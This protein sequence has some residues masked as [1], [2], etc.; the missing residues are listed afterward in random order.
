MR[1]PLM[2]VWMT[3]PALLLAAGFALG[4]V[5][6]RAAPSISPLTW[7]GGAILFLLIGSAGWG[8]HHRR[9]VS[10]GPLIT[11]GAIAGSAITIGGA[12][13]AISQQV[14]ANHITRVMPLKAEGTSPILLGRV[15]DAPDRDER[16]IR[17]TLRIQQVLRANDTLR[18][19]GR[20]RAGLWHSP[21]DST[22]AYPVVHQGALLRIRASVDPLPPRLN[23]ADFDYGAYLRRR[24]VY[25]V[26]NVYDPESVAV[27]EQAA[28]SW[29]V[30]GIVSARRYVRS[31]IRRRVPSA[32]SRGVLQALLLGDRSGISDA[33]QERFARTGLMHLLA[34][35]G[36]HVLL[37]GMVLYGL[38]GPALMRLGWG[39]RS[40]EWSRAALTMALLVFYALLTGGRPSVVRAV[41]MASLFIGGV[42]LQRPTYSLNTLGVAALVLL[43][44]RPAALFDA[45][46]QLSFAAVSAIV[47]MLPGWRRALPERWLASKGIERPVMVVLVSGAATL[48]TLPVLLYHFGYASFAGLVL[49]VAAIPLTALSMVAG[50]AMTAAGGWAG[51]AADL[52]GQAASVLAEGLLYTADVGFGMLHWATLSG[53]VPFWL[54]GIG[55]VAGIAGAQRRRLR[56]RGVIAG[57]GLACVGLWGNVIQGNAS[58]H[59]EVVFFSVGHGDAALVSTP[60]NQHVLIDTGPRTPFSDAAQ[61]TVLPHLERE[62]INHLDAVVISHTD[63]DHLGGLPSLLRSVS[64]G[65][66]VHNGRREDSR[67][68]HTVR[69]LLDSLSIRHEPVEAGDTLAVDPSVHMQVLAPIPDMI[70]PS[71]NDASVVLSVIFGSTQF[72]FAGD[73]EQGGEEALLHRYRRLHS[74]VIKVPHHGSKTSSTESFVEAVVA[75]SIAHPTRAVI[76]VGAGN[77][78]GLPHAEVVRRWQEEGARVQFTGNGAVWLRSDGARVGEVEWQ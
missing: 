68:Y 51:A 16:G 55:L 23:P 41:V 42:L 29:G 13:Y 54:I 78:F 21:W 45:G 69:H 30:Q 64:V 73:I 67:L 70:R 56:W 22:L 17:F 66:V 11:A 27:D 60:S 26:I 32:R 34:I 24:G 61:R 43:I 37:I 14:P 3:P 25:G 8:W 7:S 47:V 1:S 52:F 65:R 18:V 20:L 75:D 44:A 58:P 38:L 57:L 19:S 10:L 72:L 74:D 28:N 12:W 4:I 49:N 71:D 36:L 76:S 62:G 2:T 9:L 31:E 40:V 59:L 5:L 48:G 77:R 53:S 50:I 39:W 33:T 6:S 35:S 46:F 15:T 63:S